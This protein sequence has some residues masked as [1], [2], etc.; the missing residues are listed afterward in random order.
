MRQRCEVPSKRNKLKLLRINLRLSRLRIEVKLGSGGT[1]T[2]FHGE[3]WAALMSVV[4]TQHFSVPSE[5][6]RA[7]GLQLKQCCGSS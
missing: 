3:L 5:R 4:N 2:E 1:G 7:Y 6:K